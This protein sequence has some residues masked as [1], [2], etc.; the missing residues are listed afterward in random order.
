MCIPRP[1]V[2]LIATTMHSPPHTGPSTRPEGEGDFLHQAQPGIPNVEFNKDGN[3][4]R[5]RSHKGNI[6]SLPQTKFCPLC[7]AKFTRSTHLNRH[8]RTRKYS[9]A[10]HTTGPRCLACFPPQTAMNVFMNVMYVRSFKHRIVCRTS[11]LFT[12]RCHSQFTRSD[13]LSRHKRSCGES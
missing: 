6:P 9:C 2:N 12:Q 7:P 4:S 11:N 1:F 8:L 10:Q 13:L 3:V 5:M